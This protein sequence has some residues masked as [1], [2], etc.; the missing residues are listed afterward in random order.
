VWHTGAGAGGATVC[1]HAG[2]GRIGRTGTSS[3]KAGSALIRVLLVD[4]HRS[5][6]EALAYLLERESDMR[7]VAQAGS[8][9]AARKVLEDVD[10]A[11][12][13]I[14]LPDGEGTEL[15]EPLRRASPG[16]VALVLSGSAGRARLAGSLRE[17]A[18]AALSKSSELPEIVAAIR[19]LGAGE[20]AL[21]PGALERLRRAAAEP[22][23]AGAWPALTP[24]EREVLQ[25][26]AEG[27]SG[28]QI[29]DRLGIS[30]ATE[31]T[32]MENIRAKLGVRSQAQVLVWAVKHEQ[33]T[34]R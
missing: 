18:A 6:R 16:S 5:F 22:A 30:E 12:L 27:L 20:G 15:L 4:D 14:A 23:D 19:R 26:L 11:V 21:A 3:W 7:V 13:D 2:P 24:R 8:V 9:R 34:I 1:R 10:V 32:H 17:G 31:R 28:R 25:G 29:A 33:V